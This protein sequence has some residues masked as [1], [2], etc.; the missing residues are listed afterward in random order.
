MNEFEFQ[1]NSL[2]T[3]DTHTNR[4]GTPSRADHGVVSVYRG[5][6]GKQHQRTRTFS[7]LPS[8]I[9]SYVY[10]NEIHAVDILR[11]DGKHADELYLNRHPNIQGEHTQCVP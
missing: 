1:T 4:T 2:P 5:C 8:A 9:L 7:Y 6:T 3:S 10:A 11:T